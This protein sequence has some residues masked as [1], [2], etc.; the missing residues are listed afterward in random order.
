[1]YLYVTREE[2][3]LHI[4]EPDYMKIV[5]FTNGQGSLCLNGTMKQI[6]S[7]TLL[8]LSQQ[9]KI[10]PNSNFGLQS[11]T[12]YFKPIALNDLLTYDVLARTAATYM[13]PTDWQDALM[14]DY[15]LGYEHE[16]QFFISLNLDTM[17]IL[18]K[19]FL[20][21][22][23]ELTIQANDYWP[24]R[25]R[26]YFIELLFCINSLNLYEE[27]STSDAIQEEINKKKELV[28]SIVEYLQENIN[29][30]LTLV[31]LEKQ[32]G[33]NRN[34]INESF[35]AATNCTV[36]VYLNKMRMEFS[37]QL[38]KATELPLSEIALRCGFDDYA[39][40]CKV[41]KKFYQV[42]PRDFRSSMKQ[43]NS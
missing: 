37:S 4:N 14:L 11:F 10:V 17:M 21:M 26:S 9:D 32:F 28:T 41:F 43:N 15:F 12:L 42:N 31:Q 36:M 29:Q 20:K 19:L 24:C 16:R 34:I 8:L 1:M 39:Y 5:L 30:K 18:S 2:Y 33:V 35:H 22:E 38:L 23:E 25:S 27:V 40:F 3:S 13:R 6:Q 7:P